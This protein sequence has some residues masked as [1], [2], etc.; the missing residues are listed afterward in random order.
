ML[1]S[2]VAGA[3]A[4]IVIEC[5]SQQVCYQ[6]DVEVSD[7][8][9][10]VNRAFFGFNDRFYYWF[11]RPVGKGYSKVVP[12]P[13]R[14]SIDNFLHNLMT[15][16]RMVNDLLQLKLKKFV[17][18]FARLL[19]NTTVG[20]GG[21][22][23]PA[24]KWFNLPR[25]DEDFGQT[26]GTW[27]VGEIAYVDWPVLGPSDVRDSTGDIVDSF[28][29]P[30]Y[31]LLNF[32]TYVGVRGFYEFNRFSFNVDMYHEIKEESFEPY[33]AVRNMYIQHRRYLVEH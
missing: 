22:F 13:V 30:L 11:L 2:L 16:I 18:E 4:G 14:R 9:E 33:V 7:P 20:V 12:E 24:A 21:L 10:P 17:I 29:D 5:A 1:L 8:F 26:L 15:P 32:W 3:S 6:E 27:G 25:Q 31:Y 23:D 28:F 19:A